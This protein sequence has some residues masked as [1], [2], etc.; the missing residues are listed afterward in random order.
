MLDVYRACSNNLARQDGRGLRTHIFLLQLLDTGSSGP[1]ETEG[2]V[3]FV[4]LDDRRWSRGVH[5]VQYAAKEDESLP[6]N[7]HLEQR[8][9]QSYGLDI[10]SCLKQNLLFSCK[11]NKKKD[12]SL[13]FA[14]L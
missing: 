5:T 12:V 13:L 9:D 4:P 8:H 2:V 3:I 6:P 7:S 10:N 14:I 1:G 11:T